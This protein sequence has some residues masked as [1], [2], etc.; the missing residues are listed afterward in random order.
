MCERLINLAVKVSPQ[1]LEHL[2]AVN[3]AHGLASRDS[4]GFSPPTYP[5]RL[6]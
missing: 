2:V 6:A 3:S 4:L 5:A 1:A